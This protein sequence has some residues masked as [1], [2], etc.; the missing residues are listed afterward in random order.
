MQNYP[1]RAIIFILNILCAIFLSALLPACTNNP[2]TWEQQ[3]SN[4]SPRNDFW[5]VYAKSLTLSETYKNSD[6][7][8]AQ[9]AWIRKHPLYFYQLI[10]KARPYIYF[11]NQQTTANNLP[12]EIALMPMIE[13]AYDPFRYSKVGATGLWDLMPGTAS[14]LGVRI[15]W[16]FDGRRSVLEST[17]AALSY[18]T[19]LHQR[20]NT[21]GLAI[22]A[23]DSGAGPIEKAIRHNKQLH[24]STKLNDLNLPLETK[25]Y[26][27]KLLALAI[28]IH[29][30]QQYGFN[31]PP[32][33]NGAQFDAFTISKQMDIKTIA[34]MAGTS[35]KIIR[36][37]NPGFRRWATEPNISYS[38]LIP[39]ENAAHFAVQLIK[40]QKNTAVSN[41]QRYKVVSGDTISAIAKRYHTSSK[42]IKELNKIKKK[43]ILHIGQILFIDANSKQL[44]AIPKNINKTQYRHHKNHHKK[45][46]SSVGEDKIP[47]PQQI[48]YQAKKGDSLYSIA[49]HY[50][51]KTQEIIFWNQLSHRHKVK[52][53]EHLI[54][55]YKKHHHN[56]K[57]AVYHVRSGDSLYIIAHKHDM[58]LPTLLKKNP[59][60]KSKS[61]LHTGQVIN[62]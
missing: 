43:Q 14:G 58:L 45:I 59:K 57:H 18:L 21:W 38:C 50:K 47:G 52:P 13:S 31:I 62:I 28:I 33:A 41:W 35:E 1:R 17:Q 40:P 27:P 37:L 49:H 23:Y 24:L 15:N 6:N 4:I 25:A 32:L 29:H 10:S 55:W 9:I 20:F 46:R 26:L 42:L 12:A 36:N 53:G 56:K 19:Y 60:L 22:S 34:K 44:A 5:H 11:I 48:N 8:K 2:G 61:T 3:Q 54:L 30:P 39:K 16:W 51:V 7:V